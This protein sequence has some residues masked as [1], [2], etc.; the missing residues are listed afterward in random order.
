MST[1]AERVQ[2]ALGLAYRYLNRRERTVSEVRRRLEREQLEPGAIEQALATLDE[3][4]YLD[5]ARFARVFVQDKREL[6]QWGRERI[7]RGLI[8][9][10]VEPELIEDALAGRDGDE[11]GS[12][13]SSAAEM[14]EG[15]VERALGLLSRR[16]PSPPR[17]RRER[18][19]ALG[20]LIRKGYDPELALDALSAYARGA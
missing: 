4:G 3:Q 19:R 20:V 7:T 1:E 17:D 8:A 9:R 13:L 10:G 12:P 2:H 18:D 6:E 15:E 11:A 14:H 5:D 16:F